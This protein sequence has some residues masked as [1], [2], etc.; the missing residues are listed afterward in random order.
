MLAELLL[1]TG[2]PSSE[3]IRLF[4]LN[5]TLDPKT[6]KRDNDAFGP[7]YEYLSRKLAMKGEFRLACGGI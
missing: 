2:I 6:D 4:V 5:L 7:D 3:L 1:T